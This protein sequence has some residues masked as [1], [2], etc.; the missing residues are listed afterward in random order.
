M[1]KY[2]NL[3]GTQI[4]QFGVTEYDYLKTNDHMRFVTLI[5]RQKGQR[6]SASMGPIVGELEQSK[7]KGEQGE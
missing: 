3:N 2:E 5:P 4:N 7:W 1:T 6:Y